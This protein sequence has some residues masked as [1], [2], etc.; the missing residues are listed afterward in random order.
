MT[1]EAFCAAIRDELA[2]LRS[3]DAWARGWS[4]TNVQELLPRTTYRV[5]SLPW[6]TRTGSCW[7]MAGAATLLIIAN[8]QNT[9]NPRT[10]ARLLQSGKSCVGVVFCT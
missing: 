9:L 10:T 3:D 4:G 7:A 6:M 8:A 1:P 5:P 2:Q